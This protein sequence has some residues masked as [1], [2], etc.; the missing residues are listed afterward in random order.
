MISVFIALLNLSL[1]VSVNCLLF[2]PRFILL[3][4]ER[5]RNKRKNTEIRKQ[6]SC[7]VRRTCDESQNETL[8]G[9]E[10]EMHEISKRD[11]RLKLI[12]FGTKEYSSRFRACGV[13]ELILALEK[14][15]HSSNWG[16]GRSEGLEIRGPCLLLCESRE[17]RLWSN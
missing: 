17:K 2:F 3:F 15:I 1:I 16:G 6:V 12:G 8:Q 4:V 14:A 7:S 9:L 10:L 13:T 11:F 5:K